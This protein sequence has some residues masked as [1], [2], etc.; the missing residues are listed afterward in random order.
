MSRTAGSR[1]RLSEAILV[2][3]SPGQAE[4]LEAAAMVQGVSSPELVRSALDE[5]L[6]ERRPQIRKVLRSVEDA[7]KVL[8]VS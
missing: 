5:Y 8:K 7:R 3:L 4:E 6:R 2:K 1:G